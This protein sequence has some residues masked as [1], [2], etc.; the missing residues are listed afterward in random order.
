MENIKLIVVITISIKEGRRDDLLAALREVLAKSRTIE[1]CIEI[2][3]HENMA[4]P[5]KLLIY[6]T[7]ASEALWHKYLMQPHITNF[8]EQTK[9]FADEWTLQKLKKIDV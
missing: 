8:S 1:G 4:T 3:V 9:D 6:E 5:N 7:W 2:V